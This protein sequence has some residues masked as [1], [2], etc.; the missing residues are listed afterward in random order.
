MTADPLAEG[1][2]D[3]AFDVVIPDSAIVEAE[4]HDIS[5]FVDQFVAEQPVTDESLADLQ[6]DITQSDLTLDP[7]HD[8]GLVDGFGSDADSASQ[9]MVDDSGMDG[10]DIP[11]DDTLAHDVLL[12][13]GSVHHVYDDPSGMG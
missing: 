9:G 11:A 2:A 5:A 6:H 8:V 7:V 3:S 10:Q 4:V 13:D 1:A 12:D